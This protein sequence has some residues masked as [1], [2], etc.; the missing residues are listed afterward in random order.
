M[1]RTGRFGDYV[2]TY[3]FP[4]GEPFVSNGAL[5]SPGNF[6][7]KGPLYVRSMSQGEYTYTYTC[8]DKDGNPYT[9]GT[10]TGANTQPTGF[11]LYERLSLIHI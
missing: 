3:T 7:G 10:S 8:T 9:I 4:D 11:T 2:Y 1:N 6:D 5:G